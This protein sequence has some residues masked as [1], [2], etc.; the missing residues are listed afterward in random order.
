[1]KFIQ[2]I[3]GK[4]EEKKDV[5]SSSDMTKYHNSKL[6]VQF[7]SFSSVLESN[8]QALKIISDLE[9]KTSGEFIYDINY[10][11]N[12]LDNLK[13]LMNNITEELISLGGK[14]Y[15]SLKVR[16]DDIINDIFT[17]LSPPTNIPFDDFTI[18]FSQLDKSM[19]SRVGSKN[20]QLGELNNKLNLPVPDGFAISAYGYKHF[21]DSNELQCKITEILKNINIKN[22]SDLE[23]VSFEISS[24]ILNSK[25]PDKLS[26][27]ILASYDNLIRAIM[28]SDTGNSPIN[29]LVSVRSSAIGEDTHLS[30]AG[31]YSTYLGIRRE[32]L[33]ETYLKV[34]A[35]KFSPKAI[36]YYLSH[37]LAESDMPMS[38][39]CVLMVNARSSGVI[40]TT[41]PVNPDN[42]TILI[43]SIFGLGK[44]LVDGTISPDQIILSK[45]NYE[46][47]EK[48]IAYKENQ[49]V[50][51]K[52]ANVSLEV[53]PAYKS[54]ECSLNNEEII[55]L[56]KIALIIEEHY[57]SPQDIEW[58]I[59][60]NNYI[61]IL[62]TRPLRVIKKKNPKIHFNTSNYNILLKSGI[63]ACPGAGIGVIYHVRNTH[64]LA[65]IP[66]SSV[67][68]TDNPFPGL[69]TALNRAS[70]LITKVAGIASHLITIA[71][72]YR[73]PTITGIKDI[74]KL[75]DGNLVTV[76]ATNSIIYDGS[77]PELAESLKSDYESDTEHLSLNILEKISGK[78]VPMYLTD[79]QSPDF[80]IENCKTIHDILRYAHQRA[81]EEMFSSAGNLK[82]EYVTYH[83]KSEIPLPVDIISI[84]EDYQST[85]KRKIE[86]EQI[87]SLP[88]K[89][90][91]KG[92]EDVGWTVPPAAPDLKSFMTVVGT[93]LTNP[94][95]QRLAEKS[96]V[97][98]S[99][100]YMVLSLNMGYH[101]S[102]IEAMC[103]EIPNKNFIKLNFKEGGAS[104]ERRLRRI[105]LLESIMKSIGFECNSKGDT[106]SSE[107]SYIQLNDILEKLFLIGMLTML[108][109][110]LDM[111]LS[112]DDETEIYKNE[113]LD[114]IKIKWT[115][116]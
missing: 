96:Y 4:K 67:I 1:M 49:L 32:N 35:S 88:F 13:N 3:F 61:Y 108:T 30:F 34:I 26:Q 55:Q 103:T 85:K 83:L 94:K 8:N 100:E 33:I 75:V 24:L 99:K 44:F 93:D 46:I 15:N 36:Y 101:F 5:P 16:T 53:L 65:A 82:N 54:K 90:F 64:D 57:G 104:F 66:D 89:S 18:P 109:K 111:A 110:Q 50:L 70:A 84:D 42:N 87:H 22:F 78:I 115:G 81:I 45:S 114:K 25:I 80:T 29:Y 31:Q 63:T 2:N 58:A 14:K 112:N 113:I 11:N 79:S 9:E 39:G 107:I 20:A 51:N 27:N 62:Q 12:S 41:N 6:A 95:T 60:K 102:T 97:V 73:I 19:V 105:R 47:V 17:E 69:I 23:K 56:A 71:R 10:I 91:W 98:Y 76:D 38:V 86:P 7:K 59:D 116:K 74:E 52:D 43:N 37:E 28:S 68:V 48:I 106:L 21:L 40:Y 77:Y 92:I 72:E